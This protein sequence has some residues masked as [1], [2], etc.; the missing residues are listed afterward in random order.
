MANQVVPPPIPDYR[1][2]EDASY[3]L[4]GGLGGLGRSI[5][6]W[7]ASRG[8]RHFIFLSR[9]GSQ[10]EIA[11]ALIA[12]LEGDG[13]QVA[14][15]ACDVSNANLLEQAIAECSSIM[16]PIRGCI[17]GAMQLKDSAFE[18]MSHS[19]FTAAIR[20][21][22]HGS[23]NLHNTLPENLDFFVRTSDAHYFPSLNAFRVGRNLRQLLCP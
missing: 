7:M 4:A 18:T 12:E 10:S 5:A 21:K 16:P 14:A 8:A 3:V 22:V 15:F 6:K 20:P 11:Q 1:F 19:D 2:P 23:F 17:Q 9:N 13:C